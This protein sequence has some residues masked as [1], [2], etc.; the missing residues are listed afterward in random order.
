MNDRIREQLLGYLLDA[1]DDAERSEVEQQLE[2]SPELRTELESL[3]TR[4]EGKK[5]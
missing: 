4:F 1:L 3:A 2:V 5:K